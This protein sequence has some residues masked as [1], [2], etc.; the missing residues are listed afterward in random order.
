MLG[1]IFF[2]LFINDM[3][4]VIKHS[5]ICIFADDTVM[6]NSNINEETMELELQQDLTSLSRWLNNNGLIFISLFNVLFNVLRF[7][8]H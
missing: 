7:F 5:Q 4:K 1:P 2:L 3:E 8:I 6:Y